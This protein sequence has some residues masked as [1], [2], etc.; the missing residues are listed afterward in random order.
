MSGYPECDGCGYNECRCRGY[1]DRTPARRARDA[2][3]ARYEAQERAEFE[4][5]RRGD[6]D[7]RDLTVALAEIAAKLERTEAQAQALSDAADGDPKHA[8]RA[9]SEAVRAALVMLTVAQS[10]LKKRGAP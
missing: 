9:V 8:F 10:F 5:P 3:F 1:D 4:P 6:P 7:A 2:A